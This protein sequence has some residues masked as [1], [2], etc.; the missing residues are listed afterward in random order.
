MGELTKT[1]S[2]IIWWNSNFPFDLIWRKKYKIPFM[3]EQ[4]KNTSLYDI[5]LDIYEEEYLN[6]LIEKQ[7]EQDDDVKYYELTGEFLKKNSE[8]LE[9]DSEEITNFIENLDLDSI[10]KMEDQ[11][12]I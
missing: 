4:H 9:M 12:K 8:Y 1:Q 2:F 7:R 3:S 6:S 5:Y 10:N 11:T